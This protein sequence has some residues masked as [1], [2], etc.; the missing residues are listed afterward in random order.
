[1]FQI[2]FS[3]QTALILLCFTVLSL[4]AARSNEATLPILAVPENPATHLTA[5]DP[6]LSVRNI[7]S[8]TVQMSWTPFGTA[9]EYDVTVTDLT[10]SALIAS[11]STANTSAIISGLTP[12]HTYR[13]EVANSGIIVDVIK[14]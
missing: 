8:G 10:S 3:T 5:E 13:Y 7:A 11:F 2:R 9:V 14:Q 6:T 1:M 12:G 4:P